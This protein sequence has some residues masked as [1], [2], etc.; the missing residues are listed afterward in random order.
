MGSSRAEDEI[1]AFIERTQIAVHAFADGQEPAPD[2]TGC[3]MLDD[4]QLSV[5]GAR[6][7]ALL[8]AA[9]VFRRSRQTRCST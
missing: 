5:A 4:H 7:L 6:S 8:N 2:T 1:C 9:V 3:V